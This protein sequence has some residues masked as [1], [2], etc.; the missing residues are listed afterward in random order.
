MNMPTHGPLPWRSLRR[1]FHLTNEWPA[2]SLP[3]GPLVYERDRY[4]AWTLK[5]SRAVCG[6]QRVVGIVGRGHLQ[7]V[8][9]AVEQDRGG[10]TLVSAVLAPSMGV[11]PSSCG[12]RWET[13]AR[14][15]WRLMLGHIIAQHIYLGQVAI[16][17]QTLVAGRCR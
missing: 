15:P 4:L 13:D 8:L 16:V 11:L 1:D 5:R 3:A 14:I 6:K 9:R 12:Q 7:G 10:D 17:Q 2:Q